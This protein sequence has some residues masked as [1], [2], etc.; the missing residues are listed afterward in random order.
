[1]PGRR[2]SRPATLLAACLLLAGCTGATGTTATTTATVPDRVDVERSSRDSD[3]LLER[4]L[5]DDAP[6]CSAAVGVDGEVVWAGARGLADLAS[7]RPLTTS[8]TLDV[9]SVS[10]QFTATAVLLLEQDGVV[11]LGDP[12]SRWVPDLPAWAGTVTLGHLVHQTSGIP[13][14]LADL[15]AAGVLLTDRRTQQDALA[16]IAAHPEL[17][18]PPGA[19][20]DYSNSNYVL[21]AEVVAAAAGRPL[22]E[23]LADRVFGPLDLAMV[24]DPSGADPANADVTSARSYT[25]TATSVPWQPAGS[26]FEQVGD[27]SVQTTPSELVRWAD[28]YRTGALGGPELLAAQVGDP[29]PVEGSTG[30]GAGLFVERTG[31]LSHAGSW[32][33]FLSGFAVSGDRRVA[34]AVS[35]NGDQA[36]TDDLDRVWPALRGEWL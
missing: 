2:S 24:L 32:A 17:A 9:G 12:L 21:L 30:Y 6:G 11:A 31:P 23:F 4:V 28:V 26:R 35:C 10:K 13:D 29:V 14:Y 33:G 15:E 36:G 16:A 20:F 25:R 8:T 27:G 19:R 1:M 3:A 18:A 34:V 22:A 7:G 5:A